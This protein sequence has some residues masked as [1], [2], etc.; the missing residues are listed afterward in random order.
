MFRYYFST[1][2]GKK[3]GPVSDLELRDLQVRGLI[4]LGT[5]ICR[6]GT[7]V[8]RPIT[9]LYVAPSVTPPASPAATHPLQQPLAFIGSALLFIGVF[10][11][12]VSVPIMGQMNYFQ[13]GKGGGTIILV[14]ALAS[15]ILAI[16][17]RFRFLWLT[18][19]A[20][21]VLLLVTFIRFQSRLSDM[22]EEVKTKLHDNPFAGFADLA[23][24]SVQIQWGLAVLVLGSVLVIAAAAI[25]QKR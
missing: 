12:M 23:I 4:P 21:L 1:R 3:E 9:P 10:C 24:E 16:V 25:R 6:E 11:P 22:K 18:G 2:D 15:A 20:S 19:G 5:R 7:D 8:W 17:N 14:L 13:N